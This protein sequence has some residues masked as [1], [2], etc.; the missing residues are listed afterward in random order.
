M[1]FDK[2]FEIPF[3][4]RLRAIA[5]ALCLYQ[6]KVRIDFPE[7]WQNLFAFSHKHIKA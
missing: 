7:T 2:T 1:T 6:D 4:S 5:G 3:A